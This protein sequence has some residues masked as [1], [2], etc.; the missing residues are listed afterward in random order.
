MGFEMKWT[1]F[2]DSIPPVD[3][4]YLTNWKDVW[5]AILNFAGDWSQ[6]AKENPECAWAKIELPEVPKEPQQIRHFCENEERNIQC[7]ESERKLIINIHGMMPWECKACPFCG[8]S[9]SKI[10]EL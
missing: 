8:Y 1:K 3:H 7:F 4:A 10:K 9:S 6:Y 2:K 5:V